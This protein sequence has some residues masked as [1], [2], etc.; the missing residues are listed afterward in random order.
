M[1]DTDGRPG[2]VSLQDLTDEEAIF[3]AVRKQCIQSPLTILPLA[4][5]GGLLL[6]TGAFSWG[7]F[8]VFAAVVSGVI[9]A[10]AFVY[11]LWIRGETLAARH[12]RKLMETMKEQ[13]RDALSEVGKVCADVG[14]SEAAKE[15]R[16]LSEAYSRYTE[17]LE[18]RAGAI[19]GPEVG[20]RLQLAEAARAAGLAHLRRAAEIHIA[21]EGI[22]ITKLRAEVADWER[23]KQS[24]DAHHAVLDRKLAAH[25]SQIDRY[26]QLLARRE[27]LI[28]RSN[29]LESALKSAHLADAGRADLSSDLRTDDPAARLSG[30]IDAA[31]RAEAEMR[32]FLHQVGTETSLSN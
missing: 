22:D 27:E 26:E 7:F 12:V 9:G 15:A 16:E 23:E 11:N 3:K 21:L 13:R 30:V 25:A 6:L 1:T 10:A 28:A 17:F 32:D 29:E 4:L 8:G 18:T 14:L 24:P 19:L 5:A 31:E 2:S 20:Q